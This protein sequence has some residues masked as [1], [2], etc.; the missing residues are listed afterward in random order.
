MNMR[1]FMDRDVARESMPMVKIN[2]VSI[3]SIAVLGKDEGEECAICLDL[4]F[5]TKVVR[6]PC[7]HTFHLLCIEQ[8][9]LGN[10]TCPLCRT[11][12]SGR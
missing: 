6:T 4:M 10:Q 9:L 11:V 7:N 2:E 3:K 5:N 1:P 12:L 8:Q